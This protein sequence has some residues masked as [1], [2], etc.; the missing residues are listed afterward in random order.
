MIGKVERV[1][2][3]EVASRY[4]DHLIGTADNTR[5]VIF[6]YPT[7]QMADL[8]GK[9]VSVRITDYI[10]PHMVQGELVEVL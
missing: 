3:E 2:V 10:S 5:S 1:L 7:E 4:P 8:M 9:M 6:P